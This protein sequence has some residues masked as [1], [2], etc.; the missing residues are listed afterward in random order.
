MIMTANISVC[1][2]Y[3]HLLERLWNPGKK[4]VL[5]VGLNPSKADSET[6]DPTVRRML[7]FAEQW[8]YGRLLVCNLF[9]WR[10]TDPREMKRAVRPC[11]KE[12]DQHILAAAAEAERVVVAWGGDGKYQDRGPR[13]LRLLSGFDLY[14]LGRT[15]DGHPRHPLYMKAYTKP[16]PYQ[17][18][19]AGV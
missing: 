17:A 10:A 4:T 13:V 15:E 2:R 18:K 6:D 5:F 3:R 1:G 11:S 8:G 7:D 16:E 19:A 12:N 9:D 14:C